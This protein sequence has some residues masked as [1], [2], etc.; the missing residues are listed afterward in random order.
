VSGIVV[1]PWLYAGVS[2]PLII[3]FGSF[4][5]N[6][7]TNRRLFSWKNI[8]FGQPMTNVCLLF[9]FV[10]AL[11]RWQQLMSQPFL[12]QLLL[13]PSFVAYVMLATLVWVLLFVMQ[14]GL[15][16]RYVDA[17]PPSCHV[18]LA[19]VANGLGASTYILLRAILL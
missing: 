6:V 16:E 5:W 1:P 13:T 15:R 2:G 10:H 4:A 14:T 7:R 9:V 8:Y 3:L 19:G 17:A 18:F 11:D 12:F